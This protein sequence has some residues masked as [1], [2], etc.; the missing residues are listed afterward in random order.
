MFVRVGKH[1]WLWEGAEKQSAVVAVKL[2]EIKA[3]QST[4]PTLGKWSRNSGL[5]LFWRFF[6][7]FGAVG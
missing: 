4:L 5:G 7:V 2:R 6:R 1:I 3:P